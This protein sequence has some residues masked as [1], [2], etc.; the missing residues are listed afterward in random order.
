MSVRGQN[1]WQDPAWAV[2]VIH[3]WFEE[4]SESQWFEKSEEIDSRI[5]R[6]FVT[7]HQWVVASQASVVTTPRSVLAAIIVL[8]QFSRN[9][10]RGSQRAFTGD[11]IARRLARGLV[12]EGLDR[13]MKV[14]ER[15]FLYLP[16]EHSENR[17]DQALAVEL[18]KSLGNEG[19]MRDAIAHKQIIDR[20]GRFPHRNVIL[21]RRSSPE[22]IALLQRPADWW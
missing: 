3:F 9:L 4:L 22:E 19:W 17:D 14:D 18:I 6:R 10:Y 7:L 8:D 12:N 1:R 2:E 16:F 21:Q 5:R 13:D 20:F 15:L 11:V